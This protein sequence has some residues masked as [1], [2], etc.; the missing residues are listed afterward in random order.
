MRFLQ[1]VKNANII[2]RQFASR[3]SSYEV[4]QQM[5]DNFEMLKRDQCMQSTL[6]GMISII[7]INYFIY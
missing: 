1:K 5:Q 6:K 3:E 2:A 7:L 4:F